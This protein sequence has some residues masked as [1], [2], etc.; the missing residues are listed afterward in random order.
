MCVCLHQGG[1]LLQQNRNAVCFHYR[2]DSQTDTETGL[3][4]PIITLRTYQKGFDTHLALRPLIAHIISR[5]IATASGDAGRIWYQKCVKWTAT[6]QQALTLT[7]LRN[8]DVKS[9]KDQQKTRKAPFENRHSAYINTLEINQ[10]LQQIM[11]SGYVLLMRENS[12]ISGHFWAWTKKLGNN[13]KY[14]A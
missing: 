4:R 9:T 7:G 12:F 11:Q 5:F 2:P 1:L 3:K 6:F 14:I 10:R 13:K 8:I